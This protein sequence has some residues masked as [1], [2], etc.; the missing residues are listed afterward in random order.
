MKK[1]SVFIFTMSFLVSFNVFADDFKLKIIHINDHH[2]H[3]R[4]EQADYTIDGITMKVNQGGFPLIISEINSL[5]AEIP[6][7]L[8][9]HAGDAFSKHLFFTVFKEKA[10]ADL[11]NLAGFDAM[12]VGNHE[13]D[14]GDG[15]LKKFID[16]VNFPLI[17]S[18]INA[19]E[20]SPLHGLIKPYIIKNIGEEKIGIIGLTVSRKTQ[21]SSKPSDEITFLDE[22]ESVSKYA[23]EL[24]AMGINKIV[25]LSHYGYGRIGELANKLKDVDVIV[26]G[27][28]HTLLGDFTNLGLKYEGPY[29]TFI[30]D[31]EGNNICVVQAGYFGFAVGD[32]DVVF[33]DEG[34]VTSC[35]GSPVVIIQDIIKSSVSPEQAKAAVDSAPNIK[36]VTLDP[37]AQKVLDH[38]EEELSAMREKVL[39]VSADDIPQ[40][41]E[42]VA[43]MPHGSLFA[44]LVAKAMAE[45]SGNADAA[46]VNATVTRD[47]VV[48]DQNITFGTLIDL[49]P[50]HDTLWEIQMTGEEIKAVIEDALD[51]ALK[52]NTMRSFPYAY[53]LRYGINMTKPYGQRV[54]ALEIT[55]KA[56]GK[57]TQPDGSKIYLI[58]TTSFPGRGRE[59]YVTFRTAQEKHGFAQETYINYRDVFKAYLQN[60][61]NSGKKLENLPE[62]MIPVK[63]Y[64]KQM[65]N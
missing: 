9:L 51:N 54:E 4:A 34:R 47:G 7:S 12:A 19:S 23:A 56:T 44:P 61:Y 30:P 11:M 6:N 63:Y 21:G 57:W 59:G 10:N 58:A 14:E 60:L 65:N 25:L 36:F 32:L 5:R 38:Y 13:F 45:Y 55:D 41:W 8:V 52:T 2:S 28:S 64:L 43:E 42:P 46:V 37:Q 31:A 1:L 22:Y 50:H 35:S 20:K 29:P 26:D 16:E 24:K 17:S 15:L 39:C 18:N 40:Q 3:L 33:N 49:L 27:D 53:G 62:D 48:K